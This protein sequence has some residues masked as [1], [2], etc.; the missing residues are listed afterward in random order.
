MIDLSGARR[1]PYS[2]KYMA[3]V[4]PGYET[5]AKIKAVLSNGWVGTYLIGVATPSPDG[6]DF[7]ITGF[8]CN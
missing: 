8:F 5:N 7:L 2:F 4:I 1:T 3:G 6:D